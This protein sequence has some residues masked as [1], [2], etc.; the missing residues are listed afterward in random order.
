MSNVETDNAPSLSRVCPHCPGRP[1]V[2][3]IVTHAAQ[4]GDG[5]SRHGSNRVNQTVVQV[6]HILRDRRRS[7]CISI[8]KIN[9]RGCGKKI[10][11][12][13]G[14][15]L[16]CGE[17]KPDAIHEN[18]VPNELTARVKHGYMLAV[19]FPV[20]GI[21]SGISLLARRQD[22]GIGVIVF[23]MFMMYFYASFHSILMP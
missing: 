7:L 16:Y 13:A 3:R 23:S 11:L 17:R 5:S 20:G 18:D 15:C 21:V 1:V 19:A 10:R 14:A 8:P 2:V 22:H 12:Q 4:I 9:S 6:I